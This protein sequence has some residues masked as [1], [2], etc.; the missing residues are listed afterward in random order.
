VTG[1]GGTGKCLHVSYKGPNKDFLY[2]AMKNYFLGDT[3]IFRKIGPTT[4]LEKLLDLNTIMQGHAQ[5]FKEFIREKSVLIIQNSWREARLNPYCKLGQDKIN[6]D[7]DEY[8]EGAHELKA[9][10]YK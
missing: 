5:T 4:Q 10:I 2:D 6:R 7:F 9:K 8:L 3:K 1:P